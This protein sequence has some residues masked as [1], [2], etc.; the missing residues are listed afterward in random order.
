[1]KNITRTVAG[2]FKTIR[3]RLQST[4]ARFMFLGFGVIYYNNVY[5]RGTYDTLIFNKIEQYFVYII[6]VPICTTIMTCSMRRLPSVTR[7][8][9][10]IVGTQIHCTCIFI[11]LARL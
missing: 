8:T 7:T 6:M 11:R 10:I 9:S 2:I 4:Y 1:M 3:V 5:R